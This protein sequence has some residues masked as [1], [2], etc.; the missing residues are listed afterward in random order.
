MKKLLLIP[1]LLSTVSL[2]ACV[3]NDEWMNAAQS[4]LNGTSSYGT[5]ANALT[6]SQ[7]SDGL[8]EALRVGTDIVVTRLGKQGGFNADNAIRIPLPPA[9]ANV[10]NTLD[11][12]GIGGMTADLE[13]RMNDAAE[14]AVPHAKDL[15]IAA[16]QQ[17]TIADARSILS[18]RQDAATQYLRKTMGPELAKK[19]QPIVNDTLAQTGAIQLY[20]RVT[21]QYAAMPF[22]QNIK[23]DMNAYVTDKAL[24]GIFYYVAQEEAAI[25]Q[26]PAKR[27][28]EILRMVFGN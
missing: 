6:A 15:F 7:I 26:N 14:R 10:H 21:G 25:R 19:V 8:K 2:G 12:I 23:T 5:S 28:T 9:L 13:N 4:V 1:L 11:K 24:D 3:T 16:I 18:G 17:M 20:D 27:T 22:V